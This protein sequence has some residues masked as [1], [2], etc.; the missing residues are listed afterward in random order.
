VALESVVPAAAVADLAAAVDAAADLAAALAPS[1]VVV[2]QTA[3]AA[4]LA[5]GNARVK[6]ALGIGGRMRGRTASAAA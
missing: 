6:P 3:D 2:D 1:V 5:P 4:D